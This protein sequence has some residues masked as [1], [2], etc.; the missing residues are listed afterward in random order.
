MAPDVPESLA[1]ETAQGLRRVA[2]GGKGPQN[3]MIENPGR[4]LRKVILNWLAG[5]RRP[6]PVLN[7]QRRAKRVLEQWVEGL[8]DG[9]V[10]HQSLPPLLNRRHCRGILPRQACEEEGSR[11]VCGCEVKAGRLYSNLGPKSRVR[12]FE[13][14]NGL[15]E[16]L[17]MELQ[18]V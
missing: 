4:P 14:A 18:L 17:S 1:L 8:E 3:A 7:T 13:V 15:K 16:S 11:L 6:W 12:P 10:L 2:A 5:S 9:V